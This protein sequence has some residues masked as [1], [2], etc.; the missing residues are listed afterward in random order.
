MILVPQ[1][2][3]LPLNTLTEVKKLLK[4]KGLNESAEFFNQLYPE[5]AE[6][7]STKQ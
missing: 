7:E 6:L 1:F 2:E 5:V 4:E 3:G